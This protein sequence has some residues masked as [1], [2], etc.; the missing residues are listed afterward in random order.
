MRTLLSKENMRVL[1]LAV[2]LVGLGLAIHST[3][4]Y[5]DYRRQ[6]EKIDEQRDTL[7]KEAELLA[8]GEVTGAA[9][10]L[11]GRDI[12]LRR[13]RSDLTANQNAAMRRA[14]VGLALLAA[15]WLL[16]DFVRQR[17]A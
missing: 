15:G 8:S 17:A 1:F 2:I 12:A 9:T 16:L 14:G 7:R 4:Q 10:P 6:I 5:V 11:A 3:Y 13:E